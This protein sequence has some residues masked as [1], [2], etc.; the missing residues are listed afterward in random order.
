MSDVVS[1]VLPL[2]LFGLC[3]TAVVVILERAGVFG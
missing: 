3:V 2:L 1:I